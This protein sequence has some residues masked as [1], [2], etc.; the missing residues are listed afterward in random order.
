MH[1]D[2]RGWSL[3]KLGITFIFCFVSKHGSVNAVTDSIN[4]GNDGLEM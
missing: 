2:K 1:D 3:E 4:I